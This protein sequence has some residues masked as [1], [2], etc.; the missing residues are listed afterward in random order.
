MLLY[1]G[2][3][4]YDLVIHNWVKR[5]TFKYCQ[6][7]LHREDLIEDFAGVYRSKLV[8]TRESK[9]LLY[10]NL[11][12]SLTRNGFPLTCLHGRPSLYCYKLN[13]IP[14]SGKLAKM[15]SIW[16][17]HKADLFEWMGRGCH[18]RFLRAALLR[19]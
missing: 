10:K 1:G 4:K 14:F 5:S 8:K 13:G 19:E 7:E 17:K 9:K 3:C 15:K 16:D 11:V 2:F 12:T 18:S 6:I